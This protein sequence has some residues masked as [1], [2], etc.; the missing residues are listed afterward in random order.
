M[1]AFDYKEAMAQAKEL[2]Q[3][4][5]ELKTLVNGKLKA[6]QAELVCAWQGDSVN[7]FFRKTEELLKDLSNTARMA[8]GVADAVEVAAKA[9][10]AAE[11][12]AEQLVKTIGLA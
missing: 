8:A 5:A 10:K 1:I 2:S 12:A 9:I 6:Q 7:L 11:D 4:S 3:I